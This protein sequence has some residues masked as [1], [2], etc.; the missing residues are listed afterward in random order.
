MSDQHK[1]D[2]WK[3]VPFEQRLIIWQRELEQHRNQLEQHRIQT[4]A[5][6]ASVNATVTFAGAAIKG[7]LLINGG[8]AVAILAFLG[9][10]AATPGTS[11]TQF[12]TLGT[13]LLAFGWGALAGAMTAGAAYLSQICFG[14]V[15]VSRNRPAKIAAEIF[16]LIAV[17]LAFFGYGVFIYGLD[18]A[19]RAF[20]V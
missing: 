11:P 10:L 17:A 1:D 8:A 4:E 15:T 12:E 3:G 5:W 20:Q 9:H 19:V 13:A 16:R 7:L 18:T 6:V 2:P 14:E